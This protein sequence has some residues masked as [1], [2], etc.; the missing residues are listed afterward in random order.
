[1]EPLQCGV[2]ADTSVIVKA[3]V[4]HL[5]WIEKHHYYELKYFCLQYPSFQ[6]MTLVL[7]IFSIFY[8][9]KLGTNHFQNLFHNRTSVVMQ[10]N[11]GFMVFIPGKHFRKIAFNPTECPP[12]TDHLDNVWVRHFN[13]DSSFFRLIID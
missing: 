8:L 9:R 5:N 7:S 4:V 13:K 10:L 2:Q 11:I 12:V 3:F 1:M 6:P